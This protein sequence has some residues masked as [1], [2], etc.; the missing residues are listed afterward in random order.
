MGP[1]R[2]Q[3]TATKKQTTA[4]TDND[5]NTNGTAVVEVVT[6]DAQVQS[7]L[8]L[9]DRHVAGEVTN[10]EV[11]QAVAQL[12]L[13]DGG[14]NAAATAA[15][16]AADNN[17]DNNNN[18]N[19]VDNAAATKT[20]KG[21]HHDGTTAT[22]DHGTDATSTTTTTTTKRTVRKVVEAANK[23]HIDE[24]MD[25]YDDNDDDDEDGKVESKVASNDQTLN[26]V[27]GAGPAM[28]TR[29]RRRVETAGSSS[30]TPRSV[31]GAL[32][33][34]ATTFTL[35][36]SLYADIPL[37]YQGAR[38]MTTFGDGKQ[39]LPDAVAATLMGVRRMLQV[40]IQ[41]ARYLR[42]RHRQ[43]YASAKRS[44]G[45][46]NK[47]AKE[48]KH[49]KFEF[50]TEVLFQASEGHDPLAKEHK[51]GFAIGDLHILFPEE[52]NAYMRWSAMNAETAAA[53]QLQPNGNNNNNNETPPE[54]VVD[55][56]EPA[57][58]ATEDLLLLTNEEQAVKD[59][60]LQDRAAMFDVRTHRMPDSWYMT[61]SELRKGSFLPPQRGRK[62]TNSNSATS[63]WG[64]LKLEAIRFLHW[65]GFD[66][67]SPTLPPPN[68][69]TVDA[70]AF[71]GYDFVG[72]V[73]EKAIAIRKYGDNNN[74]EAARVP[75]QEQLLELDDHQQLT[76]H[77]IAQAMAQ[78]NP[79]PLYS[80]SSSNNNNSS[81]S[82]APTDM[83]RGVK[84]HPLYFGP[85][86]ENR[87]EMEIE[88]F[89]LDRQLS[90]E[91]EQIRR[92]EDEFFANLATTTTDM[93]GRPVDH[94]RFS[95]PTNNNN[96]EPV[97]T[98][99]VDNALRPAASEPPP[100]KKRRRRKSS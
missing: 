49:V 37:G 24:D 96:D 34:E 59:G 69:D 70:L 29:K 97:A 35:D 72:R 9:L 50:S 73:V 94:L 5:D 54:V 98:A 89:M 53:K 44:V 74:N 79:V 20:K 14:G 86:F 11:E 33:K 84:A 67:E 91:E 85:G 19:A 2:S 88:E 65:C 13:L 63:G 25:N 75:R 41:D 60:H 17:N 64:K 47:I 100:K 6:V 31:S 45:A 78:L 39:P 66:P 10:H 7:V 27:G 93:A 40:A 81:S 28:S 61:Y 4:A 68:E 83:N 48:F 42:R 21:D 95:D 16:A 56:V 77:D 8:D 22:G 57:T 80:S 36:R 46:D 12:L 82:S 23:K 15:A 87:L 71:L 32:E 30:S 51:C 52:L 3:K 26:K 90:P 55:D 76:A 62:S 18:N 99:A 58:A 1:A 38:M 92:Q 43:I